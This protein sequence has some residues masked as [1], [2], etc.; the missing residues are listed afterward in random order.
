[1][2]DAFGLPSRLFPPFFCSHCSPKRS[3]FRDERV[4]CSGVGP[5]SEFAAFG[6]TLVDRLVGSSVKRGSIFVISEPTEEAEVS[7]P[8]QHGEGL[9]TGRGSI[10]RVSIFAVSNSTE[11]AGVLVPCRFS[12]PATHLCSRR[13]KCRCKEVKAFL[14][15]DSV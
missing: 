14:V 11:G 3:R 8:D 15:D 5:G 9:V 1:M 2:S 4:A 7:V 12:I 6:A 13:M 10:K